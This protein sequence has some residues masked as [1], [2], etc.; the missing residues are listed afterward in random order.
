MDRLAWC[1]HPSFPNGHGHVTPRPDGAKARCGGPAL[2]SVC[3]RER[4]ALAV[5]TP[6]VFLKP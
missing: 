3:Q 2:C 1:S 4:A 5:H 6:A